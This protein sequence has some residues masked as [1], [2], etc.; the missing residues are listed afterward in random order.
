MEIVLLA[1]GIINLIILVVLLIKL[2]SISGQNKDDKIN[3]ELLIKL[4][5]LKGEIIE[6][7]NDKNTN[8]SKD[9][10]VQIEGLK[11]GNRDSLEKIND[12]LEKRISGFQKDVF[13][14]FD[15]ISSAVRKSLSDNRTETGTDIEKFKKDISDS[16]ASIN[17][18]LE[19]KI[20]TLQASNEGK[21]EKMR[22]TVEEKLDKTLNERLK[23]SFESVSNNLENVQKGLG[24]MQSLATDVG[25]L[26]RAIT[27]VKT[28]GVFGE[29]Q[30]ERILEQMLNTAQYEKNVQVKS[31][32]QERVEFAIKLPGK[33]DDD[34][35]VYLPIDSKFPSE[36]HDA[37]LNAY[38]S[39][40]NSKI[41]MAKVV[42]A[43]KIKSF[44]KGISEKYIN[45]PKTADFAILF[46]P[47][48]S[49]YAE[50]VQAP[51]LFEELQ[52]K[53]KITVTGPTTLSAFLNALHMGFK[54]L[55]I[56]KRSSE[57]WSILG[58][59]KTEF[60]KFEATITNVQKRLRGA[61]EELST[62]VGTR[63][64]VINRRLRSVEELPESDTRTLLSADVDDSYYEGINES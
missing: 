19:E 11:A 52:L 9:I 31:R 23:L 18:T 16:L 29:V 5:E 63:T 56:E 62:L 51:G 4:G 45:P 21:L 50:V 30:L 13:E 55:V 44:A 10:A 39:G 7:V 20:S 48:E 54:T 2:I 38:E 28:R 8:L 47:F 14:K 25:G 27:N 49:L 46:L 3:A 33:N 35:V 61:D 60:K 53:Y 15:S 57:V 22:E 1:I 42:F 37:L 40:D 36:D 17:K 34:S 12:T 64:N 43:N 32:S 26:K 59:V 24:E 58:A 6:K 41:E